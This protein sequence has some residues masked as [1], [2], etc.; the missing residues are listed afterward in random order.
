MRTCSSAGYALTAS[1]ALAALT[2]CSSGSTFQ[3]APASLGSVIQSAQGPV[4]R[5]PHINAILTHHGDTPS[6]RV[7]ER[8]GY[9][10][11]GAVGKPLVFVS[12]GTS[13]VDIY[14]QRGDNKMVGQITGLTPGGLATDKAASLYIANDANVLVYPPP[15][16][17]PAL[18][19]DD[20]GYLPNGVAVSR[21]GVVGVTNFCNASCGSGSGNVTFYAPN[22]TTPCATVSDPVNFSFMLFGAFDGRGN[23]YVSGFSTTAPTIG[24]IK[25]GCQAKKIT[26]LTAA[27]PLAD[28]GGGI[29]VDKHDKIAIENDAYG[30]TDRVIDT[31]N[32]PKDGSLGNPISVTPLT[33][34]ACPFQF[35]FLKSG[36][37]LYLP[38]ECNKTA[39]LYPYP[40]GGAPEKTITVGGLPYGVA[41]TPALVP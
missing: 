3:A 14:L 9:V 20:T 27:N 24:E 37:K 17:N 2:A 6:H 11:R 39:Y 41:V 33:S 5:N 36:N 38:D 22:S 34:A 21:L 40:G 23:F 8:S 4:A 25:G 7:A 35:A 18:T 30:S 28:A 32:H 16:A 29:Q 31:Y 12:D 26:L 15:Y 10:A 13:S 1:V 19:L